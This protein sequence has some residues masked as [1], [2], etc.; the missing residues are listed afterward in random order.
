MR[1]E[2]FTPKVLDSLARLARRV[3][4]ISGIATLKGLK[5]ERDV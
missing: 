2:S 3:N 1:N 5:Y 4:A